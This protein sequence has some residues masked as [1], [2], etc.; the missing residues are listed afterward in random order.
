VAWAGARKVLKLPARQATLVAA[1]VASH[2]FLDLVVHR[3]DLTIAGGTSK[4]GFAVWDHPVPAF[5]LEVVL[6]VA[7]VALATRASTT[8]GAQRG[9]W[10]RLGAALVLVQAAITFGPLPPSLTAMATTGIVFYG[11]VA[12]AGVWVDRRVA[13]AA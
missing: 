10:L 5:L 1:V 2:W 3:S 13:A 4:L 11:I 7:G 12:A 6:I 8:N 9:P